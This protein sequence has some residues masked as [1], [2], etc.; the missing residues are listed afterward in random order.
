MRVCG[1]RHAP[2][3]LPPVTTRYPLYRRLGGP[4]SQSGQVRK[5]SPPPGLLGWKSIKYN[6]GRNSCCKQ[7]EF[8][9]DSAVLKSLRKEL[10]CF[11]RYVTVFD[12]AILCKPAGGVYVKQY[13]I[14]C[15]IF[16]SD[17][18]DI[19]S[20]FMFPSLILREMSS[21]CRLFFSFFFLQCL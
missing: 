17:L 10:V 2:A 5:S 20:D 3:A 8:A 1:Q 14:Y 15:F 13:N 19:K 9:F 11:E 21:T 6:V 4:Q 7:C 16:L 18:F 12:V